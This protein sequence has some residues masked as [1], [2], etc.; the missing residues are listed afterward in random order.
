MAHRPSA[1]L[2]RG[3]AP[4]LRERPNLRVV[5]GEGRRRAS[6]VPI[7]IVAI[8]TVFGVTGIRAAIGQDGLKAAA[9]ERAYSHEQE[10][11]TLLR[12]QVAELSSPTRIA[13]E[14]QRI[15][16][17]EA[18]DPVYLRLP[19]DTAPLPPTTTP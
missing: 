5:R 12:A 15:G 1:P 10:N 19:T 4:R 2:R 3:P 11:H 18:N 17:V 16:M 8:L 14:A 7:I 6:A 13:E 9:L